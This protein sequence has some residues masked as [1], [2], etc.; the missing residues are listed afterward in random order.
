[1]NSM[2]RHLNE[3]ELTAAVACTE[4]DDAVREH[5]AEC[6]VCHRQVTALRELIEARRE[7][8]AEPIPDWEAQ[9]E[10]VM[11]RLGEIAPARSRRRWLRPALAA[12]AA[13]VMAVG[14]GVLQLDN[15]D[16]RDRD[17]KIEEILAEAEA[18]LADDSIPGFEVIDPGLVEL[19]DY[20]G[21]GVS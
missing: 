3:D 16:G 18:L 6:L 12:A 19:E 14:V 15:S 8:L 4:L 9:R 20:L 7:E 13:V 1:M 10:A 21:N 11:E 5:L 2:A 17:L